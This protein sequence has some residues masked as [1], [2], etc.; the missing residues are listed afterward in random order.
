M[1]LRGNLKDF[2]LPDVFQLVTFSKKTGVLRIRRADG[3]EGSVW[4]RDGDV[5]FAQS[6]W[7]RAPLG[8]RLAA[9]ERITPAALERALEVRRTEGSAG[10]RLGQILVDEGY[11][12]EK[13]LETFVGEQIQE[14]IFDL[15]RWDE[16][17]FDF[18]A[19][20]EIVDEDIG[21]SVSIENV[22]ME[23]SRRLEEWNRIKKK[24]P[25]MGIVFKMATAPGEG[26]FEISLKPIEWQLLLLMD[27]T[28]SVSQLAEDTGRTD[29]DVAR[30]VYGL[31][32]A[33]L[34]E[35]AADDEVER[36]RAERVVRDE[37]LASIR[38]EAD[39]AAKARAARP[40]AP[41]APVEAVAHEEPEF[42]AGP[43]IEP[44]AEDMAVFERM[45]G[46]VLEAPETPPAED[47]EPQLAPAP[48]PEQDIG[49]FMD[50]P[51]APMGVDEARYDAQDQEEPAE[52]FVEP[53]ALDTLAPEPEPEPAPEPEPEPEPEP[54]PEP[55]PEPEIGLSFPEQDQALAELME[56]LKGEEE[57]AEAEGAE[58]EAGE[59]AAPAAGTG[60]TG[61][62][63][64]DLLALG[65]G[66]L[67]GSDLLLP[68]EPASVSGV[69]QETEPTIAELEA[70]AFEA[71]APEG[72]G[73]PSHEMWAVPEAG[74]TAGD[75]TPDGMD[76]G[77]PG[78]ALL[79]ADTGYEAEEAD[80]SDLL[81]SLESGSEALDGGTPEPA[82]T[83][84]FELSPDAQPTG[85]I[86][87]DA[88][89]DEIGGMDLGT[90]IGD[91]LT[92]L[93]GGG[94]GRQRPVANV[95]RIP[96]PSASGGLQMDQTVDRDLVLKIID[97]IKSL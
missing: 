87:T 41:A 12:S 97:G 57:E 3:I 63:E 75:E 9:A 30:I 39:L 67:H 62:L 56:V 44:T 91:E 78:P 7:H 73:V 68:S 79:S 29:F 37:K 25:S 52:T 5:F 6:N 28:R 58:A 45:M 95:K 11:I 59:T 93:T 71:A 10:R 13:V 89:L 46:A 94:G 61:D 40:A 8:E 18:E 76:L 36:L 70:A 82:L 48:E 21:L 20:P 34:L 96:E 53:L 55:E 27:G 16:G 74:G 50:V 66:E 26:T 17:E 90:G 86:S 19:M 1:A 60:P 35:I 33:G 32:S 15:M 31:F 77:E 64:R 22:V 88:F 24:V 4:F 38:R 84:A 65:L 85:V 72:E 49:A 51:E 69:P 43:A 23:G 14:T 42:L 80:F 2:S 81:S 54:A 83:E 47:T 92:A